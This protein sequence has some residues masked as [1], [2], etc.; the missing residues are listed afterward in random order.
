[1]VDMS[2]NVVFILALSVALALL[3]GWGFR[4][5]PG[6][7]WQIAA[8][9]PLVRDESGVWRGMNLTYYGLFNACAYTMG[10]AVA[11]LLMASVSV[12]LQKTFSLLICLLLLCVPASKI[13]ARVVE[14]KRHTFTV[15][16]ASFVG[17]VAA[18]WIIEVFNRASADTGP[19]PTTAVLAALSIAYA[20]GE[21]IGRLACISFG[22]CYGKPVSKCR[23]AVRWLFE[24]WSFTFYGK[25]RKIAYADRLDGE[26]VVPV[27]AITSVL[28]VGTGLVGMLLFLQSRTGMA[29][30]LCITVTQ[31]WR[32][33]SEVLRADYRGGGRISSYQVMAA[34]SAVYSMLVPLFVTHSAIAPEPDLVKGLITLWDPGVLLFLEVLWG[35]VFLFTGCSTVTGSTLSFH[36]HKDRI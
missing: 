29:F 19:V 1:M 2:T 10:V 8:S 14:K 18:P 13:V 21:G 7:K 20:F 9:V 16:G 17:I 6:E 11:M 30:A 4:T 23:P 5:L 3:L 33:I 34:F 27:Q 36:V 15:G 24:R 26:K 22:C 28:Y 35:S 31:V 12:P 25:T 32:C